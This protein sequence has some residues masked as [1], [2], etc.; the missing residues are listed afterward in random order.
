M[1]NQDVKAFAIAQIFSF[2]T[3]EALATTSALALIGALK[4]ERDLG[5]C[6]N[7]NMLGRAGQ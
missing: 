1:R 7:L 5:A 3:P 6:S 4:S 2:M